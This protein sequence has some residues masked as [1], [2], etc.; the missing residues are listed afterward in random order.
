MRDNVEA[1]ILEIL[2]DVLSTTPEDLLAQPDLVSHEWD[3]RT[4]LE[5]LAQ[6]ESRFDITLDF[7]AYQAVARVADF[8]GLVTGTLDG[9]TSDGQPHHGGDPAAGRLRSHRQWQE[10][11]A[12]P[13]GD[14]FRVALL[15]S[16]TVDPLVPY[17][18]VALADA[19]VPADVWVGPFNQI[20]RQCLDDESQTARFG[21]QV[22][23]VAPRFEELWA[24][25]R[26]PLDDPG[27]THDADLR[28]L[29]DVCIGAADRWGAELLFVLPTLPEARPAGIGD[30]G[31]AVGVF[32]TAARARE[33]LRGRLADAGAAVLDAE[34]VV[35][36][37]GSRTAY[38]PD[39]RAA[40]RIPFSE[41]Y[42][43][44][45]AHRAV[46]LIRLR[47]N[48]RAP[49]VV[50]DASLLLADPHTGVRALMSYLA[51]VGRLGA[52]VALCE[53]TD[54]SRAVPAGV[55]PVAATRTG[56]DRPAQ[57]RDMAESLSADLDRVLFLSTSAP[58]VEHMGREIPEL[59]TL[60]LPPDP[61][62]WVDLLNDSGAL[63]Q[64]RPAG[65]PRA[66]NYSTGQ[67]LTLES[68]LEGLR[69]VVDCTPLPD[70][71]A[72][73]AAD[74]TRRV[75]EFTLNGEIWSA[76]RVAE[77]LAGETNLCW[78]VSARDRFGDHGLSGLVAAHVDGS[79]LVVDLWLLTCPV[80]GK[81]VEEQVLRRLVT[82]A[83]ATGCTT[84]RFAYRRTA[85]NGPCHDFLSATVAVA[86]AGPMEVTTADL[87]RRLAAREPASAAKD[88]P[89]T[90]PSGPGRR[91]KR[92]LAGGGSATHRITTASE[93]LKAVASQ[94][95]EHR[96]VATADQG[97]APR[98]ETERVLTEV[99]AEVLRR[100][101][102]GVDCS[103]FD[104]G[105]DSMLAVRLIA[106]AN[107]AGLRMTLRQVFQ[108]QTVA[109]LAAVAT[110][111][112]RGTTDARNRGPAPLLPL[113]AWFFGLKLARPNH[114]NQSQRF[115]VPDDVDVAALDRAVAAL[116]EHHQALRT[117]FLVTV[118]GW[119]QIDPGPPDMAPFVHM[120]LLSTPAG[121]W[122]AVIAKH[123]TELQLAMSPTEGRLIQFALYTFGV[124]QSP[125]LLVILHHLAIDGISWRI[126]LG[127]LQDAYHQACAGGPV[128]LGP[129]TMPAHTWA[130]HLSDYAQSDEVRA[131]LSTWLTPRRAQV[132]PVPLD[133]PDAQDRGV[134]TH[135]HELLLGADETKALLDRAV[136]VDRVSTDVLLLAAA[137][138]T[139]AR[140]T[141]NRRFLM[142]VVNHGREPFVDGADLS[143]TVA[144]LVMNVPVL[145][146]LDDETALA[147]LVPVVDRQLRE[148][149]SHHGAGDNLLRH[150]SEDE[151]IRRR[152]AALP[153]GDVLFSYAGRVD[154]SSA[155]H[156][157]L[158]RRID[159]SG[160]DMDPGATTPYALQFDAMIFGDRMRLEICYRGTQ[161]HSATVET[162]LA[163]WASLLRGLIDDTYA[164]AGVDPRLGD[165]RG[166]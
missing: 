82:H 142:D 26:L 111:V 153:T 99:F 120:D 14:L 110:P 127:D 151:S 62:R 156:P 137:T 140:W 86:Q 92:R 85:R 158:G 70:G 115:E 69:L 65:A 113:Q 43:E 36:T 105:G 143:R 51:E 118:A 135:T 83:R 17:L 117:R 139:L 147:D 16:F 102:A 37:I 116:L 126:V 95:L 162:L 93:V 157:L 91:P 131:E 104:S 41:E 94:A 27:P 90:S 23:V 97:A 49:L 136:H 68:F 87:T 30:D 48:P 22:L 148:W 106:K 55:V 1:T 60:L 159:D 42:F 129:M 39:L 75:A 103:F 152:L 2:G 101:V 40:T 114:F 81:G 10:L 164:V 123:E 71:G 112:G 124:R 53:A 66:G 150:L 64:V 3:S 146:E 52:S 47:R 4:A 145:F 12:R 96:P 122:D 132:E 107:Q 25:L 89:D 155:E 8:V 77:H 84:I 18:G 141:G 88:V 56:G 161:Y 63:D 33:A 160:E 59:T 73:D 61:A 130:K 44:M 54:E 21:P 29:A 20:E 5:V 6:I 133:L 165:E 58:V 11:A 79:A 72:D 138:R 13:R 19:S 76:E 32:A 7:R 134:F 109:G 46:R 166:R 100:P 38:R 98:T 163:D 24:G 28:Y 144:W 154:P 9:R 74:L 45:L 108:H 121:E 125:R 149:S 35:R 128:H 57:V 80:L 31:N 78:G 119:R 50:L 67:A 15:A 34:G